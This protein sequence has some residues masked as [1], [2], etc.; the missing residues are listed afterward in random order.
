MSG[1]RMDCLEGSFVD[2]LSVGHRGMPTVDMPTMAE[3]LIEQS[4]RLT[5]EFLDEGER[6]AFSCC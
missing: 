2:V 5:K 4:V 6:Y 1:K 3:R